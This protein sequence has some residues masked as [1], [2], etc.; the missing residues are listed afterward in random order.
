M[1]HIKTKDEFE[2]LIDNNKNVIID[3]YANWCGPC[4]MLA[5]VIENVAKI[6]ED[7]VKFVK[8]DVDEA[9][10]LAKMF[11]IRSIPTVVYIKEKALANREMGFKTKEQILANIERFF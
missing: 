9:E 3:F 7:K 2:K 11:D 10:E 8:V 6:Q 1:E 4:K 5:P